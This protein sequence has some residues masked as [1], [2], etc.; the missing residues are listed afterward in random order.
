MIRDTLG[1]LL[2]TRL[3]VL[4]FRC[5][6][7]LS[8][9][10]VS[11]AVFL[12]PFRHR[13]S[14][15]LEVYVAAE[16]AFYL[17]VYLPRYHFLQRPTTHP[18]TASREERREL[19][20]KYLD[21]IPDPERW[22]SLW[23]RGTPIQ[24]IRRDNIKEWLAWAFLNKDGWALEDEDELEEYVRGTEGLLDL[25]FK[26]GRGPTETLRVSLDRV[27]MSHRPLLYYVVRI[28]CVYF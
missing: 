6:T 4:Y 8:I 17:L 16:A 11:L 5:I 21:T 26:A 1:A 25:K 27:N 10:Y 9:L 23:N 2:F 14:L 15:A 28:Y 12:H 7:P 18:P 24:S 22:I 13:L 3:F 20:R 19:F